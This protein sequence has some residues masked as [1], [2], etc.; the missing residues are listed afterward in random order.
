M[1]HVPDLNLKQQL[2]EAKRI[3]KELE[4]DIHMLELENIQDLVS[5]YWDFGVTVEDSLTKLNR[6]DLLPWLSTINESGN[7]PMGQ[8]LS[9]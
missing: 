7:N 5:L 4:V 9:T 3:I 2:E 6:L 1:T 8:S